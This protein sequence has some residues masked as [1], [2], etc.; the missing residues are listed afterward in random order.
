MRVGAEPSGYS[1]FARLLTHG[2]VLA[3]VRALPGYAVTVFG[4]GTY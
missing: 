2:Q 3:P 1:N 4:E